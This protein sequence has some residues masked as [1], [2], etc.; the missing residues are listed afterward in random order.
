VAGIYDF[1]IGIAFLGFGRVLY[2]H[3]EVPHP[4]HWAYVRFAALLLMIFGLMF[5]AVAADPA[6]N[7]N[8]IPY[9]M[10]LKLSYVAVAGYYWFRYDIPML[11]KPFLVIDALMLVL[12]VMAY[13]ALG[14]S[15]N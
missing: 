11:F 1:V 15:R 2:D 3:F 14:K 6:R 8:L 9:G 7:R 12:F 4:N 10:L 5:F 13:A